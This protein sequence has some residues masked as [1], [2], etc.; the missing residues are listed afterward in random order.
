MQ[1]VMLRADG[2]DIPSGTFGGSRMA[3]GEQLSHCFLVP[4]G[5]HRYTLSV[6]ESHQVA[7]MNEYN[8]TLDQSVALR[9]AP[10]GG[11][12]TV[13]GPMSVAPE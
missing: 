10:S 6:D 9:L 2:A 5:Q 1:T 3:V 8:N 12:N 7:E 13:T 4:A 11:I